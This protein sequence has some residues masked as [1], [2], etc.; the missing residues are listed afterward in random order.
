MAAK[1]NPLNIIIAGGGTG[2]HLF[3]GVAIADEFISRGNTEVLFIGVDGNLEKRVLQ[4][5][6]YRFAAIDV[7]GVAGKSPLKTIKALYRQIKAVFAVLSIMK[8]FPPVFVLGLGGYASVPALIAAKI[9][10]KA[11]AIAEQN[12]L[13]GIANRLLAMFVDRVFISI[14]SSAKYFPKDKVCFTGNPV[15][16]GFLATALQERGEDKAERLT[17]LVC[18]G[19]QGA[20]AINNTLLAVIPD[21]ASERDKIAIIHQCGYHANREALQQAY[22]DAGIQARVE[23]F[24]DD[25]ATAMRVADFVI[26]RAGATTIAELTALGKPAL[27]IPFPFAANN[28]QLLNARCLA[29]ASAALLLEESDLNAATLAR[30][31][32][33][34]INDREKLAAMSQKAKA[35]GKPQAAQAVVNEALRMCGRI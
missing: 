12:S 11:T 13:P 26:S 23:T 20:R 15:R 2:G 25:M 34:I 16:K 1:A 7:A 31:L 14:A 35:L 17:L 27:L 3:P 30:L 5:G 8:G 33:E 18:G 21:L 29:S 22:S 4:Q 10:G 32:K 9:K 19:S 24:I 6:G 28:H